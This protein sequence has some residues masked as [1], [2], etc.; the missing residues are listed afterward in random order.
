[1]AL[2]NTV[3]YTPFQETSFGYGSGQLATNYATEFPNATDIVKIVIEYDSGNW[4]DTGHISTPTSG[5]ALSV[6]NKK[7]KTWTVKGQRSDVDVVLSQLKFFPAD[8]PESRPYAGDNPDGFEVLPFKLNV[9]DGEFS[10]EQPPAIG[11]TLFTVRIYDGNGIQQGPSETLTFDPVEPSYDNQRP[12]WS[13]LP[14]TMDYGDS[15][16]DSDDG[17]TID[18]GTI[19]HGSDTENVTIVG[20]FAPWTSDQ[21]TIEDG[22]VK[23]IYTNDDRY[24]TFVG[25]Q[26]MYIGNVAPYN[27]ENIISSEKFSIT[28][29]I[30]QCQTFLDNIKFKTKSELQK[31]TFDIHLKIFDGTI[32]SVV[33]KTMWHPQTIS[34]TLLQSVS[35]KED[36]A[37]KFDLGDFIYLNKDD[38]VEVNSY[39]AVLTLDATG[40]SGTT[41][42]TTTLPSTLVTQTYANGVLTITA[43]EFENLKGALRNLEFV[44]VQDF[45]DDFTF[46]VDFE[47]SNSDVGSS[48][49]S[50]QQTVNV[51]GQ[52]Q[53]EVANI[54]RTHTWKEDQVYFF[55]NNNPL[56]IRHPVNENFE[57]I[58]DYSPSNLG[59]N[60]IGQLQTTNTVVTKSVD[61]NRVIK[62]TGTRDELNDALEK[63]YFAPP[64]D[65]DQSFTIDV[66][67]NRTSG[68]LTFETPSTGVFTMSAIP[69]EEYSR[70]ATIKYNWDE[71]KVL[72]FET[73]LTILDTSLDDPLLEAYGGKFKFSMRA[74][75]VDG[76]AVSS[77]DL[78]WSCWYNNENLDIS[79]SGTVSDPLII[80]G[81]RTDMNTAMNALRMTPAADFTATQDFYLELRLERGEPTDTFYAQYLNFDNSYNKRV[82]FYKGRP[83]DEFSAPDSIRFGLERIAAIDGYKIVDV[84]EGKEYAIS[85]TIDND[86]EGFL[87][88]TDFGSAN[89]TVS[90]NGKSITI[91]GNKNDVNQVLQTL[92]YVPEFNFDS[93]F[94]I[95]YYQL[96]TTDN[97]T[98]ANGSDFISMVYDSALPKYQL[99]SSTDLFYEEDLLNQNDCLIYTTL[100]NLDGAEEITELPITYKI[101]LR[102]NPPT[103]IHFTGD[104]A[105]PGVLESDVVE[106][107]GSEITFTG[108]R[109]YCNNKI[110]NISFDAIADQI[111]DV[112][113]HYTQERYINY[114]FNELQAD[115]LVGASLRVLRDVGEVQFSPYKQFFTTENSVSAN[116]EEI[117][118][119]YLQEFATDDNGNIENRYSRP[120]NIQD[121]GAEAGGVTLYKLDITSSNLPDGM[122]IS[123]VGY[124]T[125]E[126]FHEFIDN[127]IPV[128][129]DK[130]LEDIMYNSQEFKV[131]MKVT[132]KLPSGTETVLKESYLTYEY[133]SRPRLLKLP[134]DF[135]W[136]DYGPPILTNSYKA[137][138]TDTI[139]YRAVL[140]YRMSD[141]WAN[142]TEL[143][144]FGDRDYYLF[145]TKG[146]FSWSSDVHDTMSSMEDYRDKTDFQNLTSNRLVYGLQTFKH[147]A[148]TYKV[149]NLKSIGGGSS[150]AKHTFVNRWG[151][152]IEAIINYKEVAVN[153]T[154]HM[155]HW[156]RTRGWRLGEMFGH[157]TGSVDSTRH[158][159]WTIPASNALQQN[160][161]S[162]ENLT[163]CSH[164]WVS[165]NKY[166]FK[167]LNSGIDIYQL[168]END[169]VV[170][171]F[172]TFK[173]QDL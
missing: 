162:N 173:T 167:Y 172:D 1:M 92:E 170:R 113:I 124:K 46:T 128:V 152:K 35:F 60:S 53:S 103:Q 120:I 155:S 157:D 32:G 91:A 108:S 66:T 44:P 109:T 48:Y 160:S 86:G 71:D 142:Q 78:S 19:N 45:A 133:V 74:K 40:I 58:F 55:K 33:K 39:R 129:A 123:G 117:T 96:Q 28:G 139:E 88:A 150:S 98:Q 93:D 14:A 134:G 26:D 116:G 37:S 5:T 8:K 82:N 68:D 159:S 149:F 36:F 23:D 29:T 80:I 130:N 89:S 47:F 169:N 97:I 63:M 13:S 90:S 132:R 76:T 110:K 104:Y 2:G 100:E 52:E 43:S 42:F 61:N 145:A 34:I 131:N 7:T 81:D 168:K 59:I 51:R 148:R 106:E 99:D 136:T 119:R 154:E 6:Y 137:S 164:F 73:G 165:P 84:A 17:Q 141:G 25:I 95:Y 156:Q 67:V 118:Q 72:E 11:D 62:F 69:Q 122:S 140:N 24:G 83:S 127:G 4:D 50:I 114:I 161:T 30:P 3:Q 144:S 146:R 158:G 70:K 171:A 79:G 10:N 75:Y 126:Q 143:T 64:T 101:K 112:D 107:N 121:H 41:S 163:L 102:L 16:Y 147:G 153:Y 22:Y 57:V 20:T 21:P 12:Y 49:N 77:N 94:R 54:T 27:T 135:E 38:L 166:A 111:G 138:E 85:L 18:F 9:T 31:S 105:E 65:F 115:N 87:R 56:Q 15:S 125:K 151:L